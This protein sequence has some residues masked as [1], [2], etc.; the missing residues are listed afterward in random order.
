MLNLADIPFF[1]G[2]SAASLARLKAS[3]PV[4]TYPQGTVIARVGETGRYF[5]AIRSGAVRVHSDGGAGRHGLLLGPGQVFGEMSLFS[6]M[7]ISATLSAA[8]DTATYCVDGATFLELLEQEPDLH[9][10]LTRLLIERLR[11]RTR[12]EQRRAGVAVIVG[13]NGDPARE[14]FFAGLMRGVTHYAPGSEPFEP[15][16]GAPLDVQFADA[17]AQWRREAPSGQY[18]IVSLRRPELAAIGPL[19]EP[20]DVILEVVTEEEERADLGRLQSVT[21]VADVGR[22]YLGPRP[23]HDL[24]RWSFQVPAGEGE[25]GRASDA[26]WRAADAPNIDRIARFLTFKEVGIAMSSGAARGFAHLGVLEVL[27]AHAV[28]FDFL[29]GTSMGG[30]TAL[31]VARCDDVRAASEFMVLHLGGNRKIRDAVMLP[32][33]S[34]FAGEKIAAAARRTFGDLTFADLACPTAVVAADL[35]AGERT[36]IDRGQVA[37]A[38][39]ATSAIPGFFPPIAYD[40]RLLVDGGIVSRVPVDV[41]ERRRCGLKIAINVLPSA[42]LAAEQETSGALSMRERMGRLLGLKG[43]LGTSW[44]LLGAWGSTQEAMRADLVIIPQTP[45]RAGFDFDLCRQLIECGRVAA[46]ERVESVVESLR[47]ML[48]A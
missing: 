45:P 9:R 21:G 17:A 26:P 33:A 41:L 18:L 8:K 38:V 25:R 22:V 29:C 19:L 23:R 48:S 2:L 3:I 27:E 6:G 30:I 36:I 34:L 42:K 1:A 5:Q 15:L 20:A 37:P 13:L 24:G 44:E 14:R 16:A 10:S 28:P 47:A 4:R 40:S 32:R 43:V 39:L 11:N 31:T 12:H 35:A 7:P 46:R